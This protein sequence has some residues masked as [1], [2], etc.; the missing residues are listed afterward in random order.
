[1]RFPQEE[2]AHRQRRERVGRV[3]R[4]S[5]PLP[6]PNLK[7]THKRTQKKMHWSQSPRVLEI[8]LLRIAPVDSCVYWPLRDN[9]V[10][11]APAPAQGS[12]QGPVWGSTPGG[13]G[14]SNLS[15]EADP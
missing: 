15:L 3:T 13:G 9:L 1:M 4:V 5:F 11:D 6:F 14:V 2:G 7:P 8:R 10:L 12:S